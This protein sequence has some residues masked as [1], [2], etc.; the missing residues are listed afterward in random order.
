MTFVRVERRATAMRLSAGLVLLGGLLLG[1]Q[2]AFSDQAVPV[3]VSLPIGIWPLECGML[4]LVVGL[5]L[6]LVGGTLRYRL[7]AAAGCLGTAS[8]GFGFLFMYSGVP[9]TTLPVFTVNDVALV[10]AA[11]LWAV[12]IAIGINEL[13]RASRRVVN[14]TVWDS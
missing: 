9:G 4:A 2:V 12:S 14:R 6:G 3:I 11:L 10:A 5:V 8:A 7:A 1:A 13:R